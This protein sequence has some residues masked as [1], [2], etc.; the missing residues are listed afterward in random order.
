MQES[1]NCQIP[2][3]EPRAG[4]ETPRRHLLSK[5]SLP[6]SP[7]E[8]QRG[9]G[10]G[11]PKPKQHRGDLPGALHPCSRNKG[12][13]PCCALQLLRF[14]GRGGTRLFPNTRQGAGGRDALGALGAP[15]GTGIAPEEAPGSQSSGSKHRALLQG[16]LHFKVPTLLDGR[17]KR[18]SLELERTGRK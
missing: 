6:K 15:R 18:A 1:L 3:T 9:S 10:A 14:A 7:T 17:K 11:V 16:R 12:K 13:A 2:G 5:S 4:G 8:A